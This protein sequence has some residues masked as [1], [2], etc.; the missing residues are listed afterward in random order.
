MTAFH[1]RRDEDVAKL[2]ELE[3]RTGGRIKVIRVSGN[4]ISQIDLK[5]MVSTAGDDRFPSRVVKG[6][7]ATIKLGARYPFEEPSVSLSTKVFNPNVYTS[8]RVC[9]G[10]K[11]LPTEFLDLLAQ[12]LFKILAFDESIVNIKSPANG[13]AARWYV[14]TKSI[15]PAAFPSDSLPVASAKPV[16][17]LKWTDKSTPQVAP[18]ANRVIV[19]CPKCQAK[20]RLPAGNSGFVPCPTCKH[21]FFVTT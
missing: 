16:S 14:R 13:E 9:L 4:P 8:G 18:S 19:T 3:Q 15:L 7:D 1:A 17:S 11:W 2:N 10:S 21:S 6:V 12:R 20:L 5:L